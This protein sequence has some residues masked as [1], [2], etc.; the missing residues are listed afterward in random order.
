MDECSYCVFLLSCCFAVV[1]LLLLFCCCPVDDE[2]DEDGNSGDDYM[3]VFPAT[4]T[5]LIHMYSGRH[6]QA[7]VFLYVGKPSP[8]SAF[9]T[10]AASCTS[11]SMAAFLDRLARDFTRG[12]PVLPLVYPKSCNLCI[13]PCHSP[14]ALQPVAVAAACFLASSASPPLVGLHHVMHA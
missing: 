13:Q 7:H 3:C 4:N 6:R 8:F 12:Q 5:H 9:L 10:A 14:S 2:D 11:L 1:L